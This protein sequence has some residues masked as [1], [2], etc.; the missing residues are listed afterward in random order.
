MERKILFLQL[1]SPPTKS[2]LHHVRGHFTIIS[3]TCHVTGCRRTVPNSF[4]SGCLDQRSSPNVEGVR[5]TAEEDILNQMYFMGNQ[6]KQTED[7]IIEQTD[8]LATL[9][10]SIVQTGLGRRKCLRL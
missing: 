4:Q 8:C 6:I 10:Y 3:N 9:S 7:L 1:F 5:G 2:M